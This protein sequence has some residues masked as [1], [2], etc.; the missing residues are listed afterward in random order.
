MGDGQG[1]AMAAADEWRTGP[2]RVFQAVPVRCA[3]QT[4][5]TGAQY[6]EVEM[7]DK[8]LGGC[9]AGDCCCQP[10]CDP[11]TAQID[12]ASSRQVGGDHYRKYK[13]QPL[14][15][16]RANN[17]PHA[18]GEAICHIVRHADKRG[19]ED[20]EK[21]IHWLQLIIERDYPEES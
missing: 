13:I 1:E 14:D 19:R 9:P 3:V 18:E 12:H 6:R 5:A 21:A 15:F 7:N 4:H 20:L 10:P 8:A 11:I 2:P 17:I 16:I